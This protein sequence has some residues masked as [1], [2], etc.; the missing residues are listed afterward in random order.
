MKKVYNI[1]AL[2]LLLT[3]TLTLSIEEPATVATETAVNPALIEEEEEEEE[4]EYDGKRQRDSLEFEKTKDPLLG[5]VPVNRMEAAVRFT[6]NLKRFHRND[7]DVLSWTARGPI[8]DSVGPSNGNLRGGFSYTSGYMSAV[9]I[10]TLNDPTGNTVLVGGTTGGVWKCTN[11]LSPFPNWT[12]VNDS[13][14]TLSV[15]YFC[16]DPTNANT[17]YYTTGDGSYSATIIFG[18]GIW[19]SIDGGNNWVKLPTTASFYRS[20]KI[21][22]DASGNVY[23]A[24]RSTTVPVVQRFGLWRSKDHGANWENITPATVGSSDSS[25]TDIEISSTG[26]LHASFGYLGSLVKHWYTDDP[27]NV[28]TATGWNVSTGIKSSG[29][30]TATVRME[31]GCS[32]NTLYALTVNSTFNADSCYKSI[33]GGATWTKQ[34]SVLFSPFMLHDQGDYDITLA[35]NPVNTNE[36]IVGGL[37]AYKSYNS[38]QSFDKQLSF[39]ATGNSAEPYVHADHHFMQ[40]WMVGAE[41]RVVIGGDGGIFLSSDSGNTWADRNKNLNIKQFYSGDMHPDAGSPYIIGGAQDNGTHQ[42]KTAGLG[43]SY[44]VTGGDGCFVHINQANPLIQWSSYVRNQYRRSVNGGLTWQI[45]NISTSGFTANPYD[46]DDG[47]N[48]LYSC[49]TTNS[50]YRW[51][52]AHTAAPSSAQ[53]ITSN[54]FL[55]APSAFKVSPYT[56]NRVFIGTNTAQ[57]LRLDNANTVTSANVAAN[58][59]NITGASFPVGGFVNCVNIGSSDQFLVAVFTNFGVNNI[60]YSNNGG[61]TW[62][63]IDG[64]LPDMPIRWAVFDPSHDDQLYIATAAGV[65]HTDAINGGST[66]WMPET[67]LPTVRTDMLKVRLSDNTLLA[68]TYGR[69]MY[70]AIIPATPEVRFSAPANTMTENTDTTIGC[71]YIKDYTFNVSMVAAPV[72]DATVTYSVLPG[73]TALAGADFDFTTNGNFDSP[74]HQHLFNNGVAQTKKITVRVYDD[75]QIES[76]ESFTLS[77]TISGATDAVA[78][79]ANKLVISILDNDAAPT[80]AA[81]VNAT[82]GIGNNTTVNSQPF[83]GNFTDSRTQFLYTAD[84][85]YAAGFSGPATVTKFGLTISSKASTFPFEGLTIKMNNVALGSLPLGTFTGGAITVFGPVS[86]P[87]IAGLNEFTLNNSFVWDGTSNLLVEVCFDNTFNVGVDI[88]RSTVTSTALSVWDRNNGVVGCNIAAGNFNQFNAAF[89]RADGSFTMV[90][91]ASVIASTLNTSRTENL[92]PNNDLYY[93]SATGEVLGRIRSLSG[94]D[95]GCTQ[96]V[97]DRAGTGATAFWNNNVANRLMDKTFHIVPD[98]NNPTGQYELTLYYSQAEKEGWEA[99]T[100]QSWNSIELVKVA[101]QINQVTP[102]NPMGAGS[103]EIVTPVRGTIGPNYTLTFTF[104]SG[105]SGFGAGIAGATLPVKLID[106]TGRL[107]RNSVVLDWKTSFELNSKGFDIERSYDGQNFEKV[108]YVGAAGNSNLTAYY[109]FIDKSIAQENNYYRLK[110]IDLDDKFEYSR[111]VF[112][113]NSL[114]DKSL[115]KVLRNPFDNAIDIEFGKVPG[116][117]VRVRLFDELGRLMMT[118]DQ[119]NVAFNRVRFGLY[120]KYLSSG[121]YL[122]HVTTIDKTYVE[123]IMKK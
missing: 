86:Y 93:Y 103:V 91:P 105:F 33:D 32:G 85:L 70:T 117:N 80:G 50:I 48:I 2:V 16:Q 39:W 19:K 120:S 1:P 121:V 104:N 112:I 20:F 38:G 15:T 96:L 35:I 62:S 41:S 114:G 54:S 102:A 119:K 113:K 44:E 74:S 22:C 110:Q 75:A 63:A 53:V 37:D 100:G 95:Y 69:G 58:L 67:G 23:A 34:N 46:Y 25:C 36:I 81:T 42:L 106:F 76:A 13:Y 122:L 4:G 98:N 60:W 90:K 72:G 65:F 40:W 26:R 9:L 30:A 10:D 55:G 71:R 7:I 6:E 52:N 78:G 92:Q 27:A 24:L 28:T 108:G 49:N 99:A 47:Q 3:L 84:E 8:F 45:R 118:W 115:F 31:L 109:Q 77:F 61:T 12:A 18:G 66:V 57:I 17:M 123:K 101:G 83:R 107:Q 43:H 82:I 87:T 5:Y 64:N 111:V 79:V 21:V 116:G 51:A 29:T 89:M 68:A 11:F 94:F 73:N 97:I 59:T 14:E 56:A 88:V